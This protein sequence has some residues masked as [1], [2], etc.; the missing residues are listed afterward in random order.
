MVLP[1]A[2]PD[3]AML[4]MP[5]APPP[6]MPMPGFAPVVPAGPSPE[7]VLDLMAEAIKQFEA[8]VEADV[9]PS[10]PTWLKMTSGK[11]PHPVDYP[12]PDVAEKLAYARRLHNEYADLRYRFMDDIK[13]IYGPY[14]A[15]HF[16]DASEDEK[17]SLY[18]DSMPQAEHELITAQLGSIDPIYQP[19]LRRRNESDEG[20]D[21]ADFLYACDAEADRLH[22]RA[23][24]GPYRPDIVLSVLLYGRVAAQIMYRID[25]DEGDIPIRENLLDPATCCPVF[26]DDRGM[27]VMVRVYRTTIGQACSAF[28]YN[29]TTSAALAEVKKRKDDNDSTNVEVIE[30]WDRWWKIIWV[31]STLVI[32]PVAH[33]LGE[34][35]FVYQMG[36]LGLP[37]YVREI[38]TITNTNQFN[39]RAL[40]FS[41]RRVTAMP[42]KGI[43]HVHML[44]YPIWL[45]E[46]IT[47]RVITQFRRA[48]D[49]AYIIYQ[50]HL[51][52]LAGTPEI[53]NTPNAK[54]TAQDGNERIELL[55]ANLDASSFGPLMQMNNDALGRLGL[56]AEAYGI[57][58]AGTNSGF[59]IEGLAKSGRDKLMP[60]LS[61]L[62]HFY[63]QMA[64][65]RL[66]LYRDWGWMLKQGG[67][68]YGKLYV[69]RPDPLPMQDP[70]LLLTP[71]TVKRTGYRV[72]VKMTRVQMKNMT[73][74]SNALAIMNNMGLGNPV[75]FYEMLGDPNPERAVERDRHYR[76]LADPILQRAELVEYLKKNGEFDK[77]AFIEA[78][79][80]EMEAAPKLPTDQLSA[81]SPVAAQGQSL[82]GLG[83]PPGPV[84]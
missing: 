6:E 39:E 65:R 70:M 14:Q 20:A 18:H 4:A 60:H 50:N 25:C 58:A 23:G 1:S 47:A 10:Y 74:V 48:V 12:S 5:P 37:G 3:P 80:A 40:T 27:A 8:E 73:T 77:A 13:F 43:S 76:M 84:Q 22:S 83:L 24:N 56:P 32:G 54:N 36:G 15:G 55:P 78:Q 52:E 17:T 82:P 59:A 57:N 35:P 29:K 67:D 7:D 9:K 72:G 44:R 41:D 71:G 38:E 63:Q 51:A 31:D 28:G 53:A 62:Q 34:P 42:N 2:N 49:P 66:K 45:R 11:N 21:K 33:K 26:D 61:T 75:Y 30:Y 79:A 68:D 64:E 16:V 81:G 46:A 69:A 19:E